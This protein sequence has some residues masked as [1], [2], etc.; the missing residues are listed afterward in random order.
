MYRLRRLFK[1]LC[2]WFELFGNDLPF[3]PSCHGSFV[4]GLFLSD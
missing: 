2:E 4:V 3:N 1:G